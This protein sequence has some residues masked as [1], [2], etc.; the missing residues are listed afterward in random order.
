[1]TTKSDIL[2]AIRHKCLDCCC[3]QPGEARACRI[4]ACPLWPFRFGSDPAPSNTRGFAKPPLHTGDL[5]DDTPPRHSDSAPVRS[6]GKSLVYTG[7]FEQ[8]SQCDAL[9]VGRSR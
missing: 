2:S 4:T 5:A 1:M 7:D 9:C 6:F 8:Q 3:G